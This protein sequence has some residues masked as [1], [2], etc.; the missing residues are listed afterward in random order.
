[1]A[2]L[3]SPCFAGLLAN[4]SI[5]RAG[6]AKM[7]VKRGSRRT[8]KSEKVKKRTADDQKRHVFGTFLIYPLR[9]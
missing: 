5:K 6:G 4:S 9:G 2:P 8:K 1:L 7:G 3:V